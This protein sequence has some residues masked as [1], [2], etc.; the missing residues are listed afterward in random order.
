MSQ[1][2]G[3]A[4]HQFLVKESQT[5]SASYGV[6]PAKLL[7]AYLKEFMVYKD[8]FVALGASM[9]E[10]S[11]FRMVVVYVS[12][13]VCNSRIDL[14]VAFQAQFPD[15]WP[16]VS[17]QT[18]SE[19]VKFCSS[20]PYV[21]PNGVVKVQSIPA[22]R[23]KSRLP[24]LI[25]LV[26]AVQGALEESPIADRPPAQAPAKATA[27]MPV[28][29]DRPQQPQPQQ[30]TATSA[31]APVHSTRRNLILLAAQS[32]MN[33][34]SQRIGEYVTVRERG[35]R[36]MYAMQRRTQSFKLLEDNL[37]KS[38]RTYEESI[39]QFETALSKYR[40]FSALKQRLSA[41]K[42][43]PLRTSDFIQPVGEDSATEL[44]LKAESQAYDNVIDLW[45]RT[46][47]RG[48]VDV[49]ACF[50]EIAAAA[51]KQFVLKF[52]MRK[53]QKK[54]T[55]RD[56]DLMELKKQYSQL[57]DFVVDDVYHNAE[58]NVAKAAEQLKKLTS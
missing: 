36:E 19:R 57:G 42:G 5:I 10:S 33:H 16:H 45:I 7:V 31:V 49:T 28:S 37:A 58:Y 39:G 18:S 23:G 27:P 22:F 8:N 35:L 56:N 54:G 41:E 40:D 47:N 2:G 20:H 11:S 26:L 17:V 4:L 1:V 12:T 13:I 53:L 43:R 3:V 52:L 50:R 29:P 25:D 15:R 46:L 38:K 44:R 51:R 34:L 24:A 30:N 55:T 6:E 9:Y 14:A 21:E 32:V 48:H